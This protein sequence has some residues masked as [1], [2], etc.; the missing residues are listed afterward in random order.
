MTSSSLVCFDDQKK[1]CLRKGTWS[2]EEDQKLMTYIN[3]YGIWNWTQIPKAAG[4]LR[5]GKSC[6]LRWMNYL[7]PG[8]KRGDF[9]GE[10]D[11]T[12]ITLQQQLGNKWSTIA[13][14]LPGRTD[15]E[16]KNHW[17]TTLKNFKETQTASSVEASY[18]HDQNNPPEVYYDD[19]SSLPNA[20]KESN[21]DCC[22][23][24]IIVTTPM[25]TSSDNQPAACDEIYKSQTIELEN[26]INIGNYETLF[27]EYQS[28]W[29]HPLLFPMETGLYKDPADFM[30]STSDRWEF[31]ENNNTYT[32]ANSYYDEDHG[33]YDLCT[34]GHIF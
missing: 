33:N 19:L 2:T 10:E 1:T 3:R 29:E 26:C 6:R 5:S 23:D 14:I 11:Q 31:Q 4:L 27:G 32:C 24:D 8:I 16:I 17:H 20:S 30:V 25:S 9:T 12:I 22:N 18:D 13:A 21:L 15:N 7:K 34:F 28:F